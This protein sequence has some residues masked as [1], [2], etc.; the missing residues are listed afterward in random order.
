[1]Q[2]ASYTDNMSGG[3]PKAGPHRFDTL[4]LVILKAADY[5]LLATTLE[6]VVTCYQEDIKIT[7]P[8][9]LFLEYHW[10]D[11]EK[12][13]SHKCNQ[14]EFLLL[15][16]NMNM[17]V[18]KPELQSFFREFCQ[19][20]GLDDESINIRQA[21]ALLEEIKE[22]CVSAVG[23]DEVDH[24]LHQIWSR[25]LETDPVPPP[26][27]SGID[28]QAQIDAE[29]NP[30]ESISAVAFLSFLRSQ[31]REYSASLSDVHYM[32]Y[33]LNS[34]ITFED[35]PLEENK[36]V[37]KERITKSRF[38]SFMMSDWNDLMDPKLG[39]ADSVD[40]THP[41]SHYWI[42]SSHD[43]Y[44]AQLPNSFLPRAPADAM[45][46]VVDVQMYVAALNRGVRCVEVDCWDGLY[47]EPVVARTKPTPLVAVVP[48][49]DVLRVLHSFLKSN[50]KSYPVILFIENHCSVVKQETMARDLQ[51]V[52]GADGM[53]YVPP[54][55]AYET[56]KLPSPEALRG[57]VLIKSKRPKTIREG[58]TV[59]DNDFDD[60]NAKSEEGEVL[61]SILDDDE[62]VDD[63]MK[64]WIIGFESAGP[65]RSN[66]PSNPKR[67]A[68]QIFEDT[69]KE[70][71]NAK[72]DAERAEQRASELEDDAEDAERFASSL[73]SECGLSLSQIKARALEERAVESEYDEGD[74]VNL[75]DSTVRR[76]EETELPDEGLEVQD[77]FGEAVEGAR[78]T[79]S[80]ASN[81]AILA[82]SA[83]ETARAKLNAA[84]EALRS[85]EKALQESYQKEKDAIEASRKAS[86][87]ARA[88]REHAD[89]ASRRVETV[90]GLLKKVKDGASS[91]ETVV[92]TAET[93]A[94]ISEQ[95]ATATE[96]K[97]SR[98]LATADKERAR[99]DIETKRE[100]RLE[101]EAAQYHE[102]C[103][104]ATKLAKSCR[105]RMEK[106]ASMLER[107]NEQIKLIEKSSHFQQEMRESTRNNGSDSGAD[108][109]PRYSSRFLDK[110]A[111]KLE[112]RRL[113]LQ[114]VKE[115]A[116][117][118]SS[119]EV[120]RSKAQAAFEDAAHNWKA[121]AEVAASARKQADRSSQIAEEL[122]EHAEEEREAAT[123]RH[124]AME[125]AKSS[126]S[127]TDAN[128]TSAQAQLA[129]AERASAEAA[130][131]ATESR[132][133][134]E[135]LTRIATASK[136]HSQAL[137]AVEE[138]K[139]LKEAAK[140][141]N[142]AALWKEM[143]LQSKVVD[144]KRLYDT[145][146]EVFS[147]AKREA[148][149]EVHNLNARRQ[150]EYNAVLAYNK[151]LLTRQQ[152]DHASALA[153]IAASA[154]VNK[155]IA[156]KHAK[157]YKDLMDM[158]SKISPD[159]AALTALH[160]CRFRYWDK[161][162]SL[163]LY[164]IH[165][166]PQSLVLARLKKEEGKI[167]D[168]FAKFTKTHIC[169]TFPPYQA[170][171]KSTN[172]NFDP[173]IQHSLGCQIVSM[174]LYSSD[175]R[176]LVNDG[177]FRA[178]GSTGYVLKPA[179]LID[180]SRAIE[181]EQQWKIS[182][183]CGSCLPKA[184]SSML[185]KNVSVG[186]SSAAL[187]DPFVR[188][189]LFEGDSGG[190]TI[191]HSTIPAKNNGLNPIWD[192]EEDTFK[193]TVS[194][195]SVAIVLFSVWDAKTQDFIA[196]AALPL[197]CFREGYRSVAL[198]DSMHTRCGPY[199][200]ASL[201]IKAQ[202]LS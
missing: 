161:S 124:I 150:L 111:A 131:V 82:S 144:A 55:K 18:K 134:A 28:R 94:K 126:V 92:V 195:P 183:L 30:V 149:A 139:F 102:I 114:L 53:L 123:L 107:C 116:S 5:Q 105:D 190:A 196:G 156:L 194:K 187:V 22:V 65:I 167:R 142:E 109:T 200:F 1:M 165:S 135:R 198:F 37:D 51:D 73:A 128:R 91:A 72:K 4:D 16:E 14:S 154:A 171:E 157:D 169:R 13:L 174:N 69:M 100:E 158:T 74:K 141:Q 164:H 35:D 152:A 95:R 172:C 159:L 39:S 6:E 27:P 45:H 192:R 42:N 163:P 36:S 63:D 70:G 103:V 199:A 130:S 193:V 62:D 185:R 2:A 48:F 60:D 110:H 40:M 71:N 8:E 125:K 202:K 188:V 11:M 19:Q 50:P 49:L 81:E 121:Q 7:F 89:T 78:T 88:N 170:T 21:N 61:D 140:L 29:L 10:I 44:L 168:E 64:G 182:L 23:I 137:R 101:Q 24:P 197:S 76:K 20:L 148:A 160:S 66:S 32:L 136:D 84:E 41:L 99:A 67:S 118:S 151:A 34:Q 12:E 26:T 181:R 58:A 143:A 122:A 47:G 86:L 75:R 59:L 9:M 175:E 77:F 153:K 108:E 90:K 186:A 98:A 179:Q 178:N 201:F 80:A 117:E 3:N 93:E 52:L 43:T 155:S 56:A 31:Q 184:D 85:A 191:I 120:K 54:V 97:A 46:C 83:T 57:K 132:Q 112:E 180:D 15:C 104:E 138:A 96:A 33:L 162:H 127:Q 177:R 145:S 189:T 38:L 166:L 115:S 147:N 146:S 25:I 79:H 17:P 113:C 106:A 87:E 173:T 133:K 119:A 176:L 68:S 129:E